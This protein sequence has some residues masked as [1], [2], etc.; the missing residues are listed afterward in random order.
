MDHAQSPVLTVR[1]YG[2]LDKEVL[3]HVS[4]EDFDQLDVQ[5]V[6]AN[7][8]PAERAQQEIVHCDR[9]KGA[10]TTGRQLLYATEEKH[11]QQEE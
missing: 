10:H 11:Y 6:A 7:G 3:P 5:V 1:E 8:H 2:C 9:G 4:L